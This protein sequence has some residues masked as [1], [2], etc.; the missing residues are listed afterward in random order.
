[1][2]EMKDFKWIGYAIECIIRMFP[3]SGKDDGDLVLFTNSSVLLMIKN[4][5]LSKNIPFAILYLKSSLRVGAH[6]R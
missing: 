1:M 4:N 6:Q 3:L 2:Q 5:W